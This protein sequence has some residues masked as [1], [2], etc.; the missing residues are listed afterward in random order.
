MDNIND[1]SIQL[2]NKHLNAF[3][4]GQIQLLNAEELTPYA[5]G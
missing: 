1:T 2:K 5:I 3:E 4:C